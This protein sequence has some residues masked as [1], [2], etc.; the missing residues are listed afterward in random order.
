M[1][2]TLNIN[3]ICLSSM[4]LLGSAV[5]FIPTSSSKKGDFFGFFIAFS[6]SIVLYF[7]WS[8]L[9]D[10]YYNLNNKIAI[11]IFSFFVFSFCSLAVCITVKNFISYMWGE[12]FP[13]SSKFLILSVFTAIL[14]FISLKSELSLT[15]FSVLA[16]VFCFL[17]IVILFFV[18][19]DNFSPVFAKG[20][21]SG[22]I[23]DVLKSASGYFTRVFL[24]PFVFAVFSRFASWKNN[25]RP[26]F[27]GFLLGFLMLCLCY[28]NSALIFSV[29][30][31][32][33][34]KFAYPLSISVVSVGN[35]FARM[36]GFAYFIIFFSCILKSAV[37]IMAVKLILI[38]SG[39][40]KARALTILFAIFSCLIG[41]II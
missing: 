20:L 7:L 11:Y 4:F 23:K 28:L 34:L 21:L 13:E 16:F 2:S 15:K 9:A 12:V 41:Y 29:S 32:A 35:L 5:L 27:I 31:A 1:K 24:C 39:V 36:D 6:L 17:S 26:D 3:R 22:K 18:S 37:A 10:K 30:Y 40:K 38:K 14:I 25:K 19:F 8:F 33:E